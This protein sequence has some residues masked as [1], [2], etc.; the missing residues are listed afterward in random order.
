VQANRQNLA[1]AV[2]CRFI[3]TFFVVV[4]C[5]AADTEA[6]GDLDRAFSGFD[7]VSD[8]FALAGIKTE[9]LAGHVCEVSGLKTVKYSNSISCNT[10][11][12]QNH[13][14]QALVMALGTKAAN[15]FLACLTKGISS[16]FA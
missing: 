16:G 7:R 10:H 4:D 11:N 6:P 1:P 3:K 9:T 15:P 2:E 8:L 5:A 13:S 12:P 14:S